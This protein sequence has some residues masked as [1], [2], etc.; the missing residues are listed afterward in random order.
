M[1][2]GAHLSRAKYKQMTLKEKVVLR[3]TPLSRKIFKNVFSNYGV[4]HV[5]AALKTIKPTI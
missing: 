2:Q 3:G 5:G 4:S 1:E